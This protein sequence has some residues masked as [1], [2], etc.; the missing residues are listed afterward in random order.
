MRLRLLYGAL[1]IAS[2]FAVFEY[3]QALNVTHPA[4]LDLP[5]PAPAPGAR[6]PTPAPASARRVVWVLIDGL[7]LD[8][9][10]TMPK[11]GILRAAGRSFDAEAGFP[12]Y[13]LPNYVTQ[14]CGL[15]PIDSGVRTNGFPGPVPLDSVFRRAKQ[16][17]LTVGVIGT[18]T[19]WFDRLFGRF[20][21]DG[22]IVADPAA[23]PPGELAL[24]HLD[25]PDHE[26][27]Q[28]GAAS[29]EYR[30]AVAHSDQVLARIAEQLDP[31]RDALI[32]TADHGHID[33][34]GH[35][36][37][38]PVSL[39][40][41]IVLW[42]AGVSPQLPQR[43]GFARDVGPTIVHLLGLGPLTHARGRSLLGEEPAAV[44]E[45]RR[46]EGRMQAWQAERA[47][48]LDRGRAIAVPIA[49]LF[50]GALAALAL[51]V[52]PRGRAWLCAPMYLLILAGLF[53]L[54]DSVSFSTCNEEEPFIARFAALASLA[55]VAQLVVGGRASAAPAVFVAATPAVVAVWYAP[56]RP[57]YDLP[58]AGLAFFPVLAFGALS[59]MAA[60]A[61]F[62]GRYRSPPGPAA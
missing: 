12:S 52:R 1:A 62:W 38:E 24:I 23:P 22:R 48:R 28:H 53:L 15:D 29:A 47:R 25:Y 54:L 40:I 3:V 5:T 34:G 20:I 49:L 46:V 36:G 21:D 44:V 9:A 19:R 26:A 43:G 17:H 11:L 60:W 16:A 6:A 4:V 27:H 51:R 57:V 41:P 45:R 56:T 32:V 2:G 59:V 37:A 8:A 30:A 42:G 61:T 50:V 14:A 55:A 35:G 58:S 31:T 39:E 13:S 7:R 10:R 18:D 33:R